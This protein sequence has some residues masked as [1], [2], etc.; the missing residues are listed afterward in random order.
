M[1]PDWDNY[2]NESRIEKTKFRFKR[3]Q[4]N[5]CWRYAIKRNTQRTWVP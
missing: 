5:V 4:R 2:R 1:R 3:V